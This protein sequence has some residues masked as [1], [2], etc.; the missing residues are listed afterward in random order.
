MA[1]IIRY[2]TESNRMR[3]NYSRGY[4]S[5]RMRN[6]Y[7]GGR[8]YR[9]YGDDMAYNRR[10]YRNEPRNGGYESN[11]S[12]DYSRDN[13]RMG[14]DDVRQIGFGYDMRDRRGDSYMHGGGG[15]HG[16][17]EMGH[18]QGMDYGLSFEEAKEWVDSMKSADGSKGGKW[19]IEDVEKLLKERGMKDDPID[20]WVGM[21]ALY[22][23]LCAVTKRYGIKETDVN[24]WVEAAQAFWL[25]DEDA[26]EDKLTVYFDCIV[27]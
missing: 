2:P 15:T 16:D 26:V 25:K 5:R 11:Y 23:D 13:D 9:A 7:R 18:G 14:Y 21:N 6:D 17:Y 8:D 10:G 22:T 3:D 27:K 1:R 4:E 19:K 24:F 20:M 12:R